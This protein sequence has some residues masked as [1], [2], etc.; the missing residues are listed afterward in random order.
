M[1]SILLVSKLLS[2]NLSGSTTGVYTFWD[3]NLM[4]L[5]FL[6]KQP[7]SAAGGV[8]H[9]QGC[10]KVFLIL[11]RWEIIDLQYIWQWKWYTLV[12]TPLI[13]Q[14]QA[15]ACVA[16]VSLVFHTWRTS[17][18]TSCAVSHLLFTQRY[19]WC[20]TSLYKTNWQKTYSRHLSLA[21]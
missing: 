3:K 18:I 20:E 21:P 1:F 4:L 7:F 6:G 9:W 16:G 8:K 19:A 15:S 2:T 11:Q 10:C 13:L 12:P 5:N 17:Q 14:S